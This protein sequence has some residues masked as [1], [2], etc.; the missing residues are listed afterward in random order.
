MAMFGWFSE[1]DSLITGVTQ[2]WHASRQVFRGEIEESAGVHKQR[3]GLAGFEYS[4]RVLDLP[5]HAK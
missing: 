2:A 3:F 1:A 4:P 5:L